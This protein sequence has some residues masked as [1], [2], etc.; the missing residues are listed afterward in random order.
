MKKRRHAAPRQVRALSTWVVGRASTLGRTLHEG[1]YHNFFMYVIYVTNAYVASFSRFLGEGGGQ[2]GKRLGMYAST[3]RR[4]RQMQ[5][6]QHHWYGMVVP[7]YPTIPY[8]T[9]PI[10]FNPTL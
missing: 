9:I 5:Q 6:H 10:R 8:H 3:R 1:T 7:T 4:F 2:I